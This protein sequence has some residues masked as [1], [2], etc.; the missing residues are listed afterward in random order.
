ML[1]S[2]SIGYN[3]LLPFGVV[4]LIFFFLFLQEVYDRY[5]K[6]SP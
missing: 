2:A 5:K 3:P 1:E 6:Y 4:G